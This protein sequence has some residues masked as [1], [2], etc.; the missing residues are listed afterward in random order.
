MP[1]DFNIVSMKM[2]FSLIAILILV[3][4]LF[5]LMKRFRLGPLAHNKIPAMRLLG[6]LSL[7]PK[8]A[9]ALVEICDQWFVVGIGTENVTL[10]S[11]VDPPPE[12][13]APDQ[14]IPAKGGKFSLLLENLGLGQGV[15]KGREARRNAE[16]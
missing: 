2:V 15:L 11:K 10:I 12:M 8:R 1:A 9:I 13:A 16:K 5:F 3:L 6:T 14:G 4:C 7:A